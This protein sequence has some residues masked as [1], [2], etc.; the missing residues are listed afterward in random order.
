MEA[1]EA[2]KMIAK[3]EKHLKSFEKENN[4]EIT[5]D[6]AKYSDTTITPKMEILVRET[7]QTKEEFDKEQFEGICV[8]VGAEKEW[9]NKQIKLNN[10]EFGIIK[11]IDSRK[12]KYPVIVQ[13]IDSDKSYK[14]SVKQVK[15]F[16][17]IEKM[18]LDK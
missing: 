10:G 7:G 5:F 12:R 17:S 9:Y 8:L 15:L 13:V 11:K 16:I 6:G 3:L 14:L 2:K 1:N 18:D 4:V